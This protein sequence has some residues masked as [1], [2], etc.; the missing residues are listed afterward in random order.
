MSRRIAVVFEDMT[1]MLYKT[2]GDRTI[3]LA[4]GYL[5]MVENE[6][7][8]AYLDIVR[9][10][11][12]DGITEAVPVDMMIDYFM[13]NRRKITQEYIDMLAGNVLLKEDTDEN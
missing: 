5:K 11:T 10:H 13:N 1:I 8:D 7:G 9:A 4:K 2:E 12:P 6:V 3:T